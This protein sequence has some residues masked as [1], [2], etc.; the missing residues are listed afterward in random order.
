MAKRILT[1]IKGSLFSAF[2]AFM[3]G[4]L[5][6]L[7]FPHVPSN[8][9][10]PD[11]SCL[12]CHDLH[13]SAGTLLKA[14]APNP[15]MAGDDTEANNLCW[16]CHTGPG[17]A[18]YRVPHSS[19]QI[20]DQYGTWNI[21]CKD[22]HNPH[23]Q[24]QIQTF[25]TEA[26]LATGTLTSVTQS[27]NSTLTDT[28]AAWTVD[29]HAGRVVFPD[30]SV[31]DRRGIPIGDLSYRIESNTATTLTL[32]G[33][34]NTAYIAAGDTYGIVYGKI[35]RSEIQAPA[36]SSWKQVKFFGATGANSFA[37]D[38]ATLDG[39]CQVCHTKTGHFKNDGTG[40]DQMHTNADRGDITGTA[41]EKC[42]EKCHLHI[43]GFGHGKGNTDVTLCIECHGHEEG[44]IYDPDG[45][46]PYFPNGST[47]TSRGFGSVIPHTTHTESWHTNGA[48]WETTKP[49][50]A[51][52]DDL[53]GPGIYCSWCHDTTNMPT[54]RIDGAFAADD[55]NADGVV[56]LDETSVCND[57]HSVDGDYNGVRSVDG[58]VGA[59]DNWHS[60]GIYDADYNFKPGKEKWCAG[61]HDKVPSHIV[62][63]ERGIDITAPKVIGD[64]EEEFTYGKG[65]GFYKTGHGTPSSTTLPATGG[66][67]AGPDKSC[68]YC[69]QSIKTHIDGDHR[70]FD[71]SDGCDSDEYGNSYRMRFFAGSPPMAMPRTGTI[72]PPQTT[73]FLL[74]LRS[75]CHGDVVTAF[76]D[77][78][79][80]PRTTNFYD[81]QWATPNLH[82]VHLV[83]NQN[84]IS[85]DWSGDWN[86]RITCI[87]C[88]NPHGTKNHSMIRTGELV[89]NAPIRIWFYNSSFGDLP[90]NMTA[91]NPENVTLGA[92]D[93]SI[94][95]SDS[96]ND[97]CA[98]HCH[99]SNWRNV[100]RSPFQVTGKTPMLNWAGVTGFEQHGVHPDAAVAGTLF[101]FMVQYR[102]YDND[103]PTSIYVWVDVNDNGS[104]EDPAEKYALTAELVSPAPVAGT[105]YSTTVT[106]NK[107]GDNLIKYTFSAADVDG[108]ATGVATGDSTLQIQN[109][110][111]TLDWTAETES[112]TSDGVH[113]DNGANGGTYQFRIKYSDLDG[114]TCPASASAN[115]QV[116]IDV[117][118]NGYEAG[119]KFNMLEVDGDADC[120]DGK[121]YYYDAVLSATGSHNYR[122]YASDGSDDAVGS[123]VTIDSAVTVA[124]DGNTV[125]V[126]GWH[127]ESCLIDG[128]QP[129][130]G[131]ASSTFKFKVKYTDEDNQCATGGGAGDIQVWIDENKDSTYDAGEKHNLSPVDGDADCTTAGGGKLYHTSPDL[132]LAINQD[133]PFEF[134]ATDGIAADN[135]IGEP[136]STGGLV[137]AYDAVTIKFSGGGDY[138]GVTGIQDAVTVYNGNVT[139][140]VYEGTYNNASLNT[141]DDNT[142]MLSACGAD[143]TIID[144][145]P[146]TADGIAL[147]STSN[148]TIDGFSMTGGDEGIYI[149]TGD[150]TLRGSKIY[151]NSGIGIQVSNAAGYLR[152]VDGS[153]IYNN[154]ASGIS[155]NGAG[156]VSTITNTIIRNNTAVSGGGIFSQNVAAA[157]STILTSVTIK[158]NSATAHGGGIYSNTGAM[159]ITDSTIINNIAVGSGGGWN[160]TNVGSPSSI[161][162]TVIADNTAGAA[163]GG[164]NNNGSNL[165]FNNSTL[166]DNVA[167]GGNGGFLANT[168]GTIAI[169]NSILWNNQITSNTYNGHVIYSNGGAASITDAI[170]QNDGDG[171]FSDG[172]YLY[173]TNIVFA[174]TGYASGNDP[175]FVDAAA[176]DYRVKYYSDAINNAGAGATATDRDGNTRTVPDLGAY[177]YMDTGVGGGVPTLT[178][179][180]ETDFAADGVNPDSAVG[181]SSF[182]FRV[183]YTDA[184]GKAPSP[185]ELWIDEDGDTLFDA[186]EKYAMAAV[187]GGGQYGDS[188]YTNG[189]RYTKSLTLVNPGGGM[190]SYR[191]AA[192]DGSQM[193]SGLPADLNTV[194]VLNRVPTVAWPGDTNYESDGVDPDAAD[195]GD[196]FTFRI[197][198]TDADNTAPVISQVWIDENDSS[199]YDAGEYYDMAAESGAGQYR[200]GDYSNGEYFTFDRAI[201]KA[202]DGRLNYRFAFSDGVDD[203][204]GDPASQQLAKE[205]YSRYFTV[206]E[207]KTTVVSADASA[208]SDTSIGIAM[209][210]T[211]DENNDNSLKVE[212][213][214][215]PADTNGWTTYSTAGHPASPYSPSSISGLTS[216]VSYDVKM[217]FTDADGVLGSSVTIDTFVLPI[218]ATTAG[219]ATAVVADETSITFSMPYSNDGNNNNT[220]TVDYKLSSEPTV[221]T[222]WVTDAAHAASPYSDTITG[223]T[224][225]QSYDIRMT[226]TD[227]DGGGDTQTVSNVT[228]PVVLTV[229]PSGCD[230]TSIQAAIDASATGNSVLV[231]ASG[232]PYSE[233]I[234]FDVLDDGVIVKTDGGTVIIQGATS[235]TNLPVVKFIDAVSPAPILDGFTIDNQTHNLDQSGGLLVQGGAN[236]TI[237]NCVI[238]GNLELGTDGDSRS[239]GVTITQ[240]GATI[241]N[242]LIGSATPGSGNHGRYGGGIFATTTAGGPYNLTITNSTIRY[243]SAY[244]GGGGAYFTSFNGAINV[245]DSILDENSISNSG[246][247]GGIYLIGTGATVDLTNSSISNNTS[248]LTGGAGIYSQS[249]L[250]ISGST[251]DGNVIAGN[252][253]GGIYLTGANAALT[254]TGG[255]VSNHSGNQYGAGIYMT[256]STAAEPLTITNTTISGNTVTGIGGGIYLDT[257]SNP[258]IF[259][260]VTVSN[261]SAASWTGGLHSTGAPLTLSSSTITANSAVQW[262]GGLYVG[263]ATANV[264]DDSIIS[265]N[266]ARGG[267]GAYVTSGATLNV[268]DS[269]IASNTTFN[270]SGGGITNN[271][272]TVN[273]TR[274]Y[275][276]G[277]WAAANGG[278]LSN[279]GA[280]GSA[281]LTSTIVSGNVGGIHTYDMGGGIYN[282]GSAVLN[283]YS[284]TIAGNYATRR[285][286]GLY[287]APTAPATIEN[288]IIYGNTSGLTWPNLE[289]SLTSAEVT[290]SDIGGW[291]GG[292]AT[293]PTPVDPIYI[294][295]DQATLGTPTAGGDYRLQNSSTL[296]DIGGG[297]N[298]PAYDIEDEL[299]PY[300]GDAD[301]TATPDIGADEMTTGNQAP[302]MD[303]LGSGNYATDG[304]DPDSA[305]SGS[306]FTFKVEYTDLDNHPPNVIYLWLDAD[307]SGTFEDPA[308]RTTLTVA[309]GE[310]G[311]YANGEIYETS[312]AL[313]LTTVGNLDYYFEAS[314]GWFAATGSPASIR[315]VQV[316]NTVPDTPTNSTPAD[317]AT[318]IALSPT[319]TGSAFND[320]DPGSSHLNSQWQVDDNSDFSSITYDSG[321]E[322]DLESHVVGTPLT[323]ATTYYWRVRYRDNLSAW[324]AAYSAGTSFTTTTVPNTPTNS[325][326]ADVATGVS[327]TPTLIASAFSDPN[328][329]SHQASRWQVDNDAGFSSITYDSGSVGDLASHTVGSVLSEGAVY[330]WRVSY[331][332][333]KGAWSSYSSG[334]SFTTNQ[335]P[336]TATNSTPVDAA[337]GVVTTPTLTASAFSD[338]N[339]GDTHA[340]S[341]WQVDDNADFSSITYDSGEVG[342]LTSHT[343][344]SS[345]A[346]VTEF[347][348]RVRYQDNNGGWSSYSTNTSFTTQANP[349]NTPINATP[350]DTATGVEVTP[351]LTGS[352]FD[353]P[354]P[355]D[356]HQASQWQVDDNADFSSITYDS[357]AVSD[358]ESHIVVTPLLG[359]TTYYWRVRYQDVAASAWS[360]YSAG[361]SFTTGVAPLYVCNTEGAPNDQIQ[362]TIADAGTTSGDKIIVCAGTYAEKVDFLGKNITLKSVSGAG[363]TTITGN[364]T[365]AAAVNFTNSETTSA[366]LDGF[367]IDNVYH[368][369]GAS[370]G[371]YIVGAT[372]TI[373]NSIIE[374]IVTTT[375]VTGAGVYINGGGATISDTQIRNNTTKSGGGIWAGGAINL[376][377]S[378]ST[379]SSNS[380]T[381]SGAGMLL[382]GISGTVEITNSSISNNTAASY[383]S[384]IYLTAAD[385]NAVAFTLTDSTVDNNSLLTLDG[386]G[387]YI[388]GTGTTT[389]QHIT[390]TITG[391]SISNNISRNG[392]AMRVLTGV[393]LTIDGTTINGNVADA[394]GGGLYVGGVYTTLDMSNCT[395]A[396][397]DADTYGGGMYVTANPATI[398]NCMITGNHNYDPAIG[399]S[400]GG[401]LM[402]N[403]TTGGT[404]YL[405]NSTVTGNYTNRYGG[406]VRLWNGSIVIGNSIVWGNNSGG[407]GTNIYGAPTV[408]YSNIG[409]SQNTYAGSNGNIDSNPVMVDM[410][411]AVQGSPAAPGDYRLCNGLADPVGCASP[412]VS[413]SIDTGTYD[414]GW[415]P[416]VDFEG[417]AR[418]FD[419]GGID[420]GVNDYDMGADEYGVP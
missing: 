337:P 361:T 306:S 202:G 340:A 214:V 417:G 378:N 107:A 219:T 3:A 112:Y 369:G 375:T 256:G 138:N 21:E 206:N 184:E 215:T 223:L 155:F 220:Y 354:D 278:G 159:T 91:P 208:A 95:K 387:L 118:D 157:N 106:L 263:A 31:R 168:N 145:N 400:D 65:W 40:A 172:P 283:L 38:D 85:G 277:N 371:I 32:D 34:I 305:S 195:S 406:G 404:L 408:T 238:A 274:S 84:Y 148:V 366:V 304:V 216:G 211:G 246:A 386:G 244:S 63:P 379:I 102:D 194:E 341:Q 356:T 42:T 35:I 71:C 139:Y 190:L 273:L 90:W 44:T 73:D 76:T 285:G 68:T 18:P 383:G 160:I 391:G 298:V 259:T 100:E 98:G 179:T 362:T 349:P 120:T 74:C 323:A 115:I 257:L 77:P 392:G 199:F 101:K 128:A 300:D 121:L 9:I 231:K 302:T 357:G 419:V 79:P 236:P 249:P 154:Q 405:Y 217:T 144:A 176:S 331:Q 135:A 397:N 30:A 78:D 398:T 240:G 313:T 247:G 272:S 69:H 113:S 57:C 312:P 143:L 393:G 262:A 108:A 218:Y 142:V 126:L 290:Y 338:P 1:T 225:S 26:F 234:V 87:L 60:E 207:Y 307:D 380:G 182:E 226:Y 343:L 295:V 299:R 258:A 254:M 410:Q 25:G 327:P 255:T 227:A 248:N 382:N 39:V 153:E 415:T 325:T 166:V 4:D 36:D 29:E 376:L 280:G 264:T 147:S 134:H 174:A 232:S 286:G 414:A 161:S 418:P 245:T 314:D 203:A 185:I 346:G 311:N 81:A 170:M 133:I 407:T 41:G 205:R 315:T 5:L 152:L 167:N 402:Y 86:S 117:N 291:T 267:G 50:G 169:S 127:S 322:T 53:R 296:I 10:L 316:S 66:I 358:L 372:P 329:D 209:A 56:S 116:W 45:T 271:A 11:I 265:S 125:P 111:P 52:D 210:Y 237:K 308:E 178:W 197:M 23:N 37:D 62:I 103:L 266:Y 181:G 347:F 24:P 163:G 43:G 377:I 67:K 282:D 276:K 344:G 268:T 82:Y 242:C 19:D 353:D 162:N 150:I 20:S 239:G 321:V 136:V 16:S 14:A 360:S 99:G 132:S 388:D 269:T 310:D 164:I 330:Y 243:N 409:P 365:N 374:D 131:A 241:E 94:L 297:S 119:E 198:Y 92:S 201:A 59:K 253:G 287:A 319:L 158:D 270:S 122:F 384:G 345:L 149:N 130:R 251:I 33:V 324:S 381:G 293:N 370:R 55:I 83:R 228:L 326:P 47:L 88:H 395:V 97:Y 75:G 401:G 229:C 46:Y 191:I 64:E 114:D 348:W 171:D 124:A 373:K 140:M 301:T 416:S 213:G 177:E 27:A 294:S 303:W 411:Q 367:T 80:S 204:T 156:N 89:G 96:V 355:G 328:G 334:T 390:A 288:T 58:S 129:P 123:P 260:N 72:S 332:D 250:S 173:S 289:S 8:A 13:G 320:P 389:S 350:V 335:M 364:N 48:D 230:Y 363:V 333:D 394:A 192:S 70:T 222:N 275:L 292:G 233:N 309:G 212:Y 279:A 51:G 175:A 196:T 165:T 49:A 187:G 368:G 224:Y 399:Y 17:L 22:C 109:V 420:D 54:F 188:D 6:A 252:R 352:T 180:G 104:Y 261:N 221:W 235:S 110:V 189:E 15:D 339:G 193:A 137:D 385:G 7:D 318:N 200:D 151:G 28:S 412:A 403:N 281:T 183:D 342:D 317:V 2:L 61:C 146:D 93:R 284:N 186:N 12:S 105:P 413:P 351:T 359:S 396:G 141:S 336:N